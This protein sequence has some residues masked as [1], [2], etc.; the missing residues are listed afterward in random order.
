MKIFFSCDLTCGSRNEEISMHALHIVTLTDNRERERLSSHSLSPRDSW[1]F[2]QLV[3][4]TNTH[5][6]SWAYFPLLHSS[7][8]E[9]DRSRVPLR[10]KRILSRDSWKM[11]CVRIRD[12]ATMYTAGKKKTLKPRLRLLHASSANVNDTNKQVYSHPK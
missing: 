12:I 5:T 11:R 7:T 9:R 1:D 6:C 3:I 10:A 2:R 4:C 8:L